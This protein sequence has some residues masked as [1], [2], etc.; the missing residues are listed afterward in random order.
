MSKV[1]TRASALL[2]AL[3][4]LLLPAAQAP[5]AEAAALDPF[6]GYLMAHFTGE[7]A[8]GEQVYFAHSRDGLNWRDLN[9]GAPVLLSTV[10]TRG[11]RDPSIV[12]S[13]A[14][15]RYWIVATDLRIASGTSWNDAANRGSRSLVVWESRDLVNWSAP[16]LINVAGAIP[17]AGNAWAPEAIY[18][19]A[20]GDYVVYW[21]TN[22]LR[23]GVTKHRIWYVRT[24]DFRSFTAPQLYIER[25]GG[26]Q[27]IIDTQ[28]VEVPGSVGGYR[29]YR[30]SA[31]GHI[32]IE[33]SNSILGSWT[34][35]GN[36]SHL[37]ISNG[38][39]GGNVVEGPM[40][41]Q[42]NGRNE[43]AL[44][45]DQYATGRGYMPVTSTNLGSVTNFRT[46]TDYQLGAS[47]KRH[48]SILN[49]TAAEESA[50]LGRWG[51]TTPANRI[52]A[53]THQDRYVR[54]A[55]YDV[56]IDANVSPAQDAQFR[57]VPGLADAAGVSFESVNYPGHY[58]RHYGFD[59]V[60]AANDGSSVF[61]ADA[62]FRQV[63]GLG[64]TSWSSFRSYNYPDRYVRHYNYQLRLDPIND[65]QARADA[66]FR[67]TS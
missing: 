45:L 52:Q 29:Y 19:A 46:R 4:L 35:L 30:A 26:G 59:F 48:G 32:T 43:W 42:F 34:T 22:S 51:A 60:L 10:G 64:N 63:A 53:Y 67:L 62:T 8:T 58:L 18:N 40:W 20:T 31:D 44:W 14:G 41:M 50:V 39:G 33:G 38:T 66:T 65:A 36:L 24:S 17:G 13:P 15:D 3:C 7:S 11:V 54:H 27:G 56:R 9:N 57:V 23:D 16:W 49:L 5:R 25:P 55:N 21:A 2:A 1:L 28:I 6:A 61:A 37:G 47:R 12:R